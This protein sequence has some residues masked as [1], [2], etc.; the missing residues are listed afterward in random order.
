LTTFERRQRIL[1]LLRERPGTRVS[2]MA[3]MLN[4]SEGTVRNDLNALA[5]RG[6]LTRVRGGAVPVERD[7]ASPAFLSRA[8][9]N[10]AAKQRIARWAAD[11]IED[12][13]SVLLDAST[14]VYHI[15]AYLQDRHNLTVVTNGIEVGRRLAQNPTNTV[16]LLG[17]LLRADGAAVSGPLSERNLRDLHIKTAF[18][19]CTGFSLEAGLTEVDLHEAQLKRTMVRAADK[20]VLLAD[21]SK[22]DRVDLT[23]FAQVSDIAQ[24][25]TDCC[26]DARWTEALRDAGIV[27]TVCGENMVSSHG[28]DAHAAPRYRIGFANL[29]EILPFAVDV[30]RGLERAAQEAGNIDLVLA[31]NQL[32]GQVALKVADD[33]IA[34]QV[35]LVIEYQIDFSAGDAIM[36]RFRDMDIPVIAVDIPMMGAT[37]FG[38]DNFKAG[39]MAGIALGHWIQARWSGGLDRLIVLE[40]PRT[41]P[42]PAARLRGQLDGLENIIGKIPAD[43]VLWLDCG[44]QAEVS[45][46]RSIEALERFPDEHRLAFV[47][48]NDDAALGAIAAGRKLD[49]EADMVVVGQGAD[50]RA[51]EEMRR[52]SSPLIGSTAYAPEKYGEKLIALALKI[53]RGEPVPPAVYM[54]HSF[55][56]RSQSQY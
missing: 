18:V 33:L 37:F 4:V 23:P 52:P 35:D 22:F 44:N 31:D 39:Q 36:G 19:S 38:V 11:L 29:C 9:I 54:D 53:L 43:R 15:A 32:D 6:Q 34:R 51:R 14:T 55:V 21:S 42:L 28:P 45:E 46:V 40:E 5:E 56:A 27:L 20:V 49:R 50:R 7:Q 17:G 47:T 16:I 3:Q 12:E 2:E 25:F 10:E 13:D 8:R 41:G 1:A 30:R 26:M 24:V 48:F